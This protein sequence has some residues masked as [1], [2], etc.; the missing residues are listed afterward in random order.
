MNL[1]EDANYK[2][3]RFVEPNIPAH[4]SKLSQFGARKVCQSYLEDKTG[5]YIFDP[6]HAILAY[7]LS[8]IKKSHEEFKLQGLSTLK[9]ED[10]VFL[11]KLFSDDKGPM[12]LL[13]NIIST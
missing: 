7:P 12:P 8:L 9:K 2:T 3:A 10:M 5:I 1:R 6:D 11:Q 4:F 13:L